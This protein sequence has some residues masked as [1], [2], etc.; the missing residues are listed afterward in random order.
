M[1]PQVISYLRLAT[2]RNAVLLRQ[3]ANLHLSVRN[4]NQFH[5]LNY[6]ITSSSDCLTFKIKNY[7]GIRNTFMWADSKIALHY[8]QN[9]DR[10]FG[11]FHRV[12]K[13]LE[14][15]ELNDWN[16]VSSESNHADKTNRYQTF[17]QL[18]LETS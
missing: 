13:I 10:S 1:V 5:N 11:M 2:N 15:T 7:K 6:K 12:N 17:K 9:E 3:N 16:Y 14:N 18:S 4:Q 8:L